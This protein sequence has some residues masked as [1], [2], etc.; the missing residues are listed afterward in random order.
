MQERK[1][2]LILLVSITI[3][4]SSFVLNYQSSFAQANNTTQ[5][6]GISATIVNS[7]LPMDSS[8][9]L[10]DLNSNNSNYNVNLLLEDNGL[11]NW[12][13][14][15]LKCSLP[16]NETGMTYNV[17][18]G[19]SIQ[20]GFPTILTS[21]RVN[22]INETDSNIIALVYSSLDKQVEK[23]MGINL[24]NNSVYVMSYD[25]NNGVGTNSLH[26]PGLLTG[27][28]WMPGTLFNISVVNH[29]NILNLM[30]NGTNYYSQRMGSD[31][32]QPGY[33]GLYYDNVN[34]I[35]LYT[36]TNENATRP[37]VSQDTET[38]LL[39]GFT[40]PEQDYLHLYD[41]TPYE[42][43]SGHITV[44]V[45]CSDDNST[46]VILLMGQSQELRFQEMELIPTLSDADETCSYHSDIAS[47]ISSPITN[48]AIYNNSTEDDID[49]PEASSVVI[50]VSEI[51]NYSSQ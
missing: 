47:T 31:F 16:M 43:T 15:I 32:N 7:S 50:S 11:C 46:D 37:V 1:A 28:T 5:S 14:M 33:T 22:E 42:I 23:Y 4:A 13:S 19:K 41:S 44:Q 26:W 35:E 21:F 39:D 36:F 45:P 9:T 8:Q 6:L 25:Y 20:S 24:F 12:E 40:L 10:T 48:I 18:P 27:L 49:F 3:L 2:I 30:I 51:S 38:I 34:S 17:M 29:N